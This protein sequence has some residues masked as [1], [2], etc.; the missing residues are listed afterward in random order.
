MEILKRRVSRWNDDDGGAID[1]GAI[2][3]KG[4]DCLACAFMW[5]R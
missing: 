4:E 1:V 2:L 5:S 3:G